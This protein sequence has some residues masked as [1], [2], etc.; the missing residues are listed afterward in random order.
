MGLLAD[1]HG[2]RTALT[3]SVV[4]MATG[5]SII[6]F[7]PTYATIGIW[8]P[9]NLIATRLLQGPVARGAN[10]EPQRPTCRKWPVR[11]TAAFTLPFNM[12][13]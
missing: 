10:T 2:R 3:I 4:I 8:S 11:T 12:S 13:P 6:A 9:L 1:R 7:V 5:S